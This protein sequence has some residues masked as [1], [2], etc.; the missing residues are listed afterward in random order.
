MKV[1]CSTVLILLSLLLHCNVQATN[2]IVHYDVG[3][4]NNMT[5]RGDGAGLNWQSGI[6][7]TYQS[8]D[9]QS[10]WVVSVNDNGQTFQF[11]PLI[12]DSAWS[13]G[14]NYIVDGSLDEYH[15]YPKFYSAN[16]SQ[17]RVT[18]I[19]D[20][21][22]NILGYSHSVDV[23]LPPSYGS[24]ANKHYPVIYMM[25]GQNLFG[26]GWNVDS[27]MDSLINNENVREAIVIGIHNTGVGRMWEYTPSYWS[28]YGDGGG[29]DQF[30]DFVESEL[31]PS[32]NARFRTLTDKNNTYIMGSSLGGLV[33][34]YAGWTRPSRY[35]FAAGLSSTFAWDDESMKA[36]VQNY[37]GP[38]IA[39][40]F[41]IDTGNY[42]IQYG[43]G[44]ATQNLNSTLQQK[45]HDPYFY[46]ASSPYDTHNETSWSMRVDKPLRIMLGYE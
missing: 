9:G 10:T 11:K 41:Y 14:D 2:I 23:Y 8:E 4:G 37:S 13:L 40:T 44:W 18:P 42:E 36:M 45:G 26:H 25:D 34:F 5:L 7:A 28:Y 38:Q 30:L 35:S 33:S 15:I 32:V 22:S 16:L 29:A 3:W 46:I 39:T 24:S 20:A 12:N 1:F 19:P 21:Y 17:G 43:G 27:T 6:T 31:M